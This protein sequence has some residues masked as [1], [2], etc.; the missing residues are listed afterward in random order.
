MDYIHTKRFSTSLATKKMQIKTTMKHYLTP[1]RMKLK[2]LIDNTNKNNCCQ[3]CGE[4][5]TLIHFP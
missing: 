4:T 2:I 3:K 5:E 1:T